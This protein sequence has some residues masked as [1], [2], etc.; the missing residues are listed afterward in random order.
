MAGDCCPDTVWD[1][2]VLSSP[3]QE[4]TCFGMSWNPCEEACDI[5]SCVMPVLAIIDMGLENELDIFSEES[6]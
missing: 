3:D 1:E 2:C 4:H 6:F 5:N